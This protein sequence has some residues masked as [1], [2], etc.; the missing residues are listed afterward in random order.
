ML[1]RMRRA[2]LESLRA[3]AETNKHRPRP[4]IY[5]GPSRWQL[6]FAQLSRLPTP[7]GTLVAPSLSPHAM[8]SLSASLVS[9]ALLVAAVSAQFQINTPNPPSQCVPVQITWTGGTPPYFLGPPFTWQTNISSG[10]SVF[11][12][13]TDNT[14]SV[15]QS[16]PV[17][18]Q[19]SPA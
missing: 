10:Q 6:A 15:A 19:S 14:G 7:V 4:R 8:K 12:Q 17:T 1:G 16:A 5:I 13:V 9:V 3:C 2:Q 11:F 18:I